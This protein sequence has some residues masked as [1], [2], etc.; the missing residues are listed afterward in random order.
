MK[1][2]FL[3][4]ILILS[5][6]AAVSAQV[7]PQI[8]IVIPSQNEI[9]APSNTSVSVTFSIEMDASSINSSSFIVNSNS[10]GLHSGGISYVD[11]TFTAVMVPDIMFRG[12][13]VVTVVLTTAIQ[14]TEGIPLESNYLWSFTIVVPTGVDVL[15]PQDSYPTNQTPLDIYIADFDNDIKLDIATANQNSA[16][17]SV[18]F[19]NGDSTFTAPVNFSV[20]E[21]P[22]GFCAADLNGDGFIDLAC[23]SRRFDN[24]SVLLNNGNRTFGEQQGYPAGESPVPIIAGDFDGDG[25]MDLATANMWS[26]DVSILLNNGD[27]TFGTRFDFGIGG[28]IDSGRD[29]ERWSDRLS[30]LRSKNKDLY[31]LLLDFPVGDGPYS[32][33]SGDL[34]RDGD[35]D[36]ATANLT[37]GTLSILF[38]DGNGNFESGEQLTAGEYPSAVRIVDLNGDRDLD[39]IC[40]NMGS[41][42]I[43]TYIND[44]NGNLSYYAQNNVG[45]SPNS[46]F[47][48]DFDGDNDIDVVSANTW[49]D[50]ITV[51]YND[52]AANFITTWEYPVG[53]GPFSVYAG[54]LTGNGAV[55]LV[56]ANS[57]S[58]DISFMMLVAGC[59]Y[60]ITGDFNNSGAFNV[61]DIISMHSKLATGSPDPGFYCECAGQEWGVVGDVNNSCT[62]N[63]SDVI[64][65]FS[66][67]KTGTPL[68]EPCDQCLP[69]HP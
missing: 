29:D 8:G 17:I 32:I 31:E 9:G 33:A 22:G 34:D 15:A 43:Y 64:A 39:L 7:T 66:R 42:S 63:I 40:A 3:S 16:D 54:D 6:F 57:G 36:L 2:S 50:N 5:F 46:V 38:N 52:G 19:N 67:L 10:T 28:N 58:N 14:S 27:G 65:G 68:I 48:G 47:C 20:G 13:E 24:V 35:L 4:A 44:S 21:N 60:Y 55:D 26:N 49:S 51:M 1:I 59:E 23:T 11:E 25:D 45:D 41:N 12:G 69:S 56:T 53:S 62:F 18:L 61:V 37:Q 30:E